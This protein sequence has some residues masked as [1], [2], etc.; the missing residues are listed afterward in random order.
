MMSDATF[1]RRKEVGDAVSGGAES[2]TERV[3]A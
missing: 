1:L 2:R 3:D